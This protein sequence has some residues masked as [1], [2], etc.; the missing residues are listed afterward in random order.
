M[1]GQKNLKVALVHDY[2]IQYGGAEKVLETLMELFPDAT[3]YTGIYSPKKVSSK[4]NSKDIRALRN[5]LIIKF[6]K[7]FTFL[8]P[9]V[10]EHFDLTAYDLIISDGTAWAKGVLTQPDQLH[11][12]YV[13]TPPR[14]LYGYS[15]ESTKRN[16]WYFKPFVP[17]IDHFLRIWDFNAAQ[18][19]GYLV[20]NSKEVQRRIKKFYARDSKLIYPPLELG[21]QVKKPLSPLGE[22]SYIVLGRLA[23]YKNV[24]VVVEAFKKMELPL[25]IVGTGTEEKKLRQR[26]GPKTKFMG[27]V[28]EK[29]KHAVLEG[30]LGV[31]NA[32]EDE[33]LGIV[34]LEAMSHGKPVFAHRSGGHL[35]TIEENVTGM[36]FDTLDVDE[37]IEKFR[38]FD[39]KVRNNEFD[40][41]KARE[42]AQRFDKERFKREFMAFI[43]AHK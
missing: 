39:K 29:T 31:I 20:A 6:S 5:P 40:S 16:A 12:S 4:I 27:G 26:A 25:V 42:Q 41:N 10:F 33:D 37:F 21:H 23:A 36:F 43:N 9:L 35:E 13:H 1:A 8:M 7:F 18:R 34:P 28:D 2:L 38:E 3:V 14:F 15:V 32:V 11:I 19:P 22:P 30:C 17:V 24:D